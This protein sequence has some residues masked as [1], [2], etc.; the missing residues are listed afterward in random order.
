MSKMLPLR[1]CGT[2]IYTGVIGQSLIVVDAGIWELHRQ[3]CLDQIR[4][5]PEFQEE[6]SQ[7]ALSVVGDTAY[8]W[9]CAKD[10]VEGVRL[11]EA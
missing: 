11:I 6:P 9:W 10:G 3:H 4:T 1:A 8:W 7:A 2:L 5:H